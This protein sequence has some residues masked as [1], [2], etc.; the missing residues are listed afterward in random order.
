MIF[1]LKKNVHER[2]KTRGRKS[3][4]SHKEGDYSMCFPYVLGALSRL[5]LKHHLYDD[6]ALC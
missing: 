2:F 4:C 3:R 6:A 5:S 1:L